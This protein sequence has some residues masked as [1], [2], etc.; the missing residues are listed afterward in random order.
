MGNIIYKATNLINNKVYIGLNTTSLE[1]RMYQHK[2]A[3]KSVNHN[4]YNSKFYRAIRKYG[5]DNFSWEIIDTSDCPEEIKEKEIYW[6]RK[7]DSY[8]NGYNSTLG[9]DGALGAVKTDEMRLAYSIAHGSKPFMVYDR[10]GRFIAEYINKEQC[11]REMNLSRSNISRGLS[12]GYKIGEYIL[13]YKD[14]FTE[15]K[16]EELKNSRKG[17]CK[18]TTEDVIEIKKM[19]MKDIPAKEIADMYGVSK[20]TI[21]EIRWGKTWSSVYVEGWKPVVNERSKKLSD[22]DVV[23][24]K[25]LLNDGELTNREIAELFNINKSLVSFIK[26]GRRY[27]NISIPQS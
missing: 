1:A 14:E 11:A 19:L 3:F 10:Q 27:S 5:W 23:E 7:Y 24:I 22:D 9:G 2:S 12:V 20:I 16:L 17:Y 13:I 15:E 21:K 26:T 4:N 8:Y 25:R 18:L 6:I